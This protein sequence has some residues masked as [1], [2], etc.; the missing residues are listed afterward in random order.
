[1]YGRVMTLLL[2]ASSAALAARVEEKFFQILAIDDKTVVCDSRTAGSCDP[3]IAELDGFQFDAETEF[4]VSPTNLRANTFIVFNAFDLDQQFFG[5]AMYFFEEEIDLG[6]YTFQGTQGET[7]DFFAF[8]RTIT[9]GDVEGAPLFAS[10]DPGPFPVIIGSEG[11]TLLRATFGQP[12][13]LRAHY[14]ASFETSPLIDAS[15]S[16]IV[17]SEFLGGLDLNLERPPFPVQVVPV[18]IPEPSG[19]TLLG[20]STIFGA[21]V[22]R[23]RS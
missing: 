17:E 22:I 6:W 8:Y 19:L 9:D 2:A 12:F 4:S 21:V 20:L 13:R 14:R 16:G 7:G 11:D 18:A 15:A 3:F 10:L 1:M 23:K 5:R